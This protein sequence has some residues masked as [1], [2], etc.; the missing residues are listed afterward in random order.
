M[1]RG[2]VVGIVE[3]KLRAEAL[4]NPVKQAHSGVWRKS[5]CVSVLHVYI[6]F[7]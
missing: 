4:L 1:S 7:V 3:G 6:I 5:V 2:V